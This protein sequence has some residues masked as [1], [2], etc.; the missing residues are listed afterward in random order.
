MAQRGID[1]IPKEIKKEDPQKGKKLEYAKKIGEKNHFVLMGAA[2]PDYPYLTDILT[3]S[4]IQISHTW[5][6]RMHYENTLPFIKGGVEVLASMNKNEEPFSIRLAW[7]CGFVSHVVADSYIHPV[8]N[9]IV[10]GS[11][12][13]THEEHG[14]CELIQ[15]IYI[16]KKLTGNDIVSANPREGNLA[17]LNILDE[18]SDP[19][20]EDKNRVHPQ[21]RDFWKKLLEMAHPD[22][23]RYF[24]DIAPDKWHYNYKGRVNF[25]VDPGAIFRHVVGLTGRAYIRE[26]EI[27]PQD[28][29]K[30]IMEIRLPNREISNYDS[31]FNK[32]VSLIVDIWLQLFQDIER[33]SPDGVAKYIKD[34]NLDTGVDESQIHLWPKKEV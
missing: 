26:S 4:I 12:I 34:W 18:C 16:F 20:D 10:H 21:V 27:T 7:F 23:N 1:R 2:G 15:D 5:A 29:E 25:V 22:A 14:K 24:D 11:Y 19:D 30:Y 6:N 32:A 31:V 8:V 9:S 3:A 33:G 28:R 13:F 17:Y